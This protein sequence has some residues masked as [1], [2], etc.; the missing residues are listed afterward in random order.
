MA[1]EPIARR[2]G[3]YAVAGHNP[4]TFGEVLRVFANAMGQLEVGRSTGKITVTRNGTTGLI[5]SVT[6]EYPRPGGVV[7]KTRTITRDANNRITEVSAAV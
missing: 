7:T 4:A 3:A 5:A 2:D 1:S 6:F